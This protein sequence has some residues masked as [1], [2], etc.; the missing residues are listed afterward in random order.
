LPG[1]SQ[2]SL[3]GYTCDGYAT[4]WKFIQQGSGSF[5]RNRN[6]GKH[7]EQLEA[8]A[9]IKRRDNSPRLIKVI[10]E[11]PVAHFT[12]SLQQQISTPPTLHHL[13]TVIVESY[14]PE[15][16]RNSSAV[17]VATGHSHQHP[18]ICGT[19]VEVLY[20][21]PC[22]AHTNSLL[23]KA[24]TALAAAVLT[25]VCI[26]RQSIS[27]PYLLAIRSLR[28]SLENGVGRIQELIPAVMCLIL[29]EVCI[30]HFISF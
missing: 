17:A 5:D 9:Q 22:L 20:E 25:S 24:V 8:P 19:W 14:L 11:P 30:L 28:K 7:H 1:C 23:S 2:C 21:L 26:S 13:L 6:S 18:R 3:S 4:G 29:V 12:P 16:E 10:P 15:S 27:E